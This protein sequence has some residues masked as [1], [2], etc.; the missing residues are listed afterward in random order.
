LQD[1]R[2]VQ[3][4]EGIRAAEADIVAAE[5]GIEAAKLAIAGAQSGI[6]ATRAEAERTSLERRR[7]EAPIAIESATQQKVEQVVADEQ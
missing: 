5:A 6:D 4:D 7:Q 2:V 1:A 3:A